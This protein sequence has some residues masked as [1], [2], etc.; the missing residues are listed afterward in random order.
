M[1]QPKPPLS[2]EDI[3]KRAHRIWEEE[4]QP[5]GAA[6]EHWRR[7][8]EELSRWNSPIPPEGEAGLPPQA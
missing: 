8:E 2:Q 5:S 7:A 1:D 6:E 3:A 4:G